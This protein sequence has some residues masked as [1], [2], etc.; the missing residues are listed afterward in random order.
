MQEREW[1][2]DRY[3]QLLHKELS[4]EEKSNL[5]KL[6]LKSQVRVHNMSTLFEFTILI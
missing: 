6:M 2:A 5:A 1:F 4:K 3:E